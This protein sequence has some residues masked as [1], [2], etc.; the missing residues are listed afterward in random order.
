[1]PPLL[2]A[3]VPVSEELLG[4]LLNV[5]LTGVIIFRPV[6]M[7]DGVTITDLAYV[8]LNPAA[9]QLLHLPECPP[10]SFLT[11]YPQ[12]QATGVF[13]FYCDAF[14]SGQVERHQVNYQDDGLDG[15]FHLV[16][17][18]Y[19]PVLVVSFTDTND[20]PRTAVEEA[21]RLSQAR[22]QAARAEAERERNL[23]Q[24]LLAQAPVAIGL[25]QGP[26]LRITTVNAQMATLWGRTPA[27]VLGQ[28]L[29]E[30]LP[31]LRGQGF[32]TQ[33]AQV[34]ATQVPVVGTETPAR[35]LRDGQLQTTYYNFVYQ[36][37]YDVQGQMLGVVNVAVEVT[38]QVRAR[39]HVQDLNEELAALNEEL[40]ASNEEYLGANTALAHSEQ[41]LQHL[42]EELEARVAA[43]TA[44]VERQRR[45]LAGFLAQAPAAI[46]VYNGPE[47]VYELVNETYQNLFGD[48]PLLGRRLLDALPELADQPAWQSLRGVY[49]TGV[50]FQVEAQLVPVAR[51]AGG[52]L[53]DRY[54]TF[55]YQARTDE[56]GRTDGVLVFAFEVTAQVKARQVSE[57][58]TRQLRVLTDALPVLIGY[59][60][61]EQKYRFANRAYENWFQQRPEALLG[62]PV[63]TVVG[64]TAYQAVRPYIARALAGERLEFTARMPYRP[65]FVRHI[66]TDYIPD[67]QA[68]GTVAG[69]YTLV[70]DITEQVL[71]REQVQRL[72]EELTVTNEELHASNTQLTRTNV[73]LDTFIYT[74]SHDLK[75]PITNIEGLLLA[76]HEHLP[77][78][79]QADPVVGQLLG[80]MGGAVERFRVTIDQL[81]DI[82]RLQHA[83]NQPAE[84]V[85]LAPMVEDVRLDLLPQLTAAGAQLTVAV[86]PALTVLLAPRN[87]RSVVF[88]LL[89]NAIKYRQPDQPAAVVL[90]ASRHGG[91]VVLAVQDNG[92]G[93]SEAQQAQVFGLFQRLHTHV[94]GTGV[95]LYM[96]KRVVENAGG[97]I[98]VQSAPG[99]GTTFTVTFPV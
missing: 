40:R 53:E 22:E 2:P 41:A 14:S 4:V 10:E 42:N 32:D 57:A 61:Q 30:A 46:C 9:Q 1:M 82:S 71:A 44:E 38:E 69:F 76:L 31:E 99:R 63:H 25:F 73:D 60:D 3:D 89:S 45:R 74:A 84:H 23:L 16:A 18:R 72:N 54:F 48:R 52:P 49:D 64:D 33:L 66:H 39:Q 13:G 58:A 51:H 34:L 97:T 67:V 6:Y 62:R 55:H 37:L 35:M 96:V 88:N 27:Q 83:Q 29:L 21:L 28:P 17:Q 20:Q 65:D 15:Y 24:V 59:L 98:V 94:E 26:E 7:A 85:P 81:T 92:L 8:R 50:P 75:Q 68:D 93:L 43:R 47:F 36:P 5:S 87:L 90:R 95:G 77:T 70:T 78:Q 79:Q 86:E 11:L 12:A 56:Q 19:G 80:L 91:R